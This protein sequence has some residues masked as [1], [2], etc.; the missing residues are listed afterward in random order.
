MERYEE[1]YRDLRQIWNLDPNNK[2]IKPSLERLHAIVNERVRQNQQTVTK[3]TKMFELAFNIEEEK[4]KR[5][6]AMSNIVVLAREKAGADV[7]IKE[8]LVMKVG[9]LL[10]MEKNNEIIVN[11][12]RAIDEVCIKSEE[13]TKMV[14]KE[15]GIPWFLTIIDSKNED[16]VGA[17]QHCM[18]T[19]LN[20]LSGMENKEESVPNK[21]LV[22]RNKQTIETLL[23]CLLFSTTER[24]ITGEARDAILEL[25]IRNAHYRT[26]DWAEKLV[27]Q[28]GL[29]R[30]MEVCSELEEYKYESA[31]N[32]TA[33][34]R[35]IASVCLARIYENMYYDAARQKFTEQINEYVKDKLLSPD[36]ESKVRVTVAITQLLLGP[37]DCGNSIISREGIME[38]IIMMA[39]TDD[40]LQQKVACECLLAAASKKDKAKALLNHGVDV[41]KKLYA[42]K[43]EEIRVRALVGLCKLGSSG[44]LDASI[45]PFADGSTTKMA[46]ACRRFLIKPG[47]IEIDL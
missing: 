28:K 37:L 4:T 11:A 36:L 32:I 14:I 30:L 33:S 47:E 19:V 44:G 22:E 18:Q 34:S 13:R 9:R 17:G 27:D 16:R 12:I 24:T 35:T 5:E 26:L 31:M 41:L 20:S 7:M 10:K 29:F 40:L 43:N 38:M 46:D 25:L 42:S 15:L 39:T 45:R 3:V 6:Q 2:T 8:G 21:E 23:S 1:A